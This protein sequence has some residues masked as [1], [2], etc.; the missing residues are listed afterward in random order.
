LMAA[1]IWSYIYAPDGGVNAMLR[2][3]GLGSLQQVWLGNPTT[4]LGSIAAVNIWMFAGY[5]CVIFLAGYLAIPADLLD[6]ADVD[7]ASGFH[8][9][10]RIEWPLLA[11]ALT[12]SVTLSLIGS[13]KVFEFPLVLTN[14]GPA[15]ATQTLTYQVFFKI[16][17]SGESAFAYGTAIALLLL[18][19]ILVLASSV[20]SA[21]RL[22][23][24]RI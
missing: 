24:R 8:R 20:N 4:A 7:G 19:V 17:G 21:L 1:F 2:D 6:A 14:G 10:W 15:N 3:V 9:F 11:P 12:V 23:E 13:L 16:F 18:V 5:S 22:R